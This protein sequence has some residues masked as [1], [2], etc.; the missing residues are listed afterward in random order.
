MSLGLLFK[1]LNYLSS[2]GYAVTSGKVEFIQCMPSFMAV[3]QLFLSQPMN[4]SAHP[5]RPLFTSKQ[6]VF[7]N[8]LETR[9][10]YCV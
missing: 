1:V 9:E 7:M 6:K 4:F 2:V 8:L 3:A 5:H 10:S